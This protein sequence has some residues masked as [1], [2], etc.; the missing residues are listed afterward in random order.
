[1]GT[2]ITLRDRYG[3]ALTT[4]AVM[5]AEHY[6]EGIDLLLEQCY[7]A[8][9]RFLEAVEADPDFALAHAA[10][11]LMQMVRENGDDKVSVA[12]ALELARKTTLRE[13]RH[14]EAVSLFIH[15]QGTRALALIL[16]H[17][18]EFPR[19]ALLMRLANRLYTLGCSG[20]GVK[21]YP[22]E[23]YGM[24]RRLEPSYGD[25]W[26]FLGQDAF[27]HHEMGF[28]DASLS[29]AERSLAGRP[30]SAHAAHSVA[31]VYFEKGNVADG[32]AFLGAWLQGFDRRAPF[33]V[34]L[35][36]HQALFELAQGRYTHAVAL[37]EEA[38]R[39]SVIQKSATSLADSASLMWRMNLYSHGKPPCPVAE[40]RDQ[41]APAAESKGPAFRD[42]HAALAFAATGDGECLERLRSRLEDLAD[43]GE[44]L[45]QEMTLPLV[46]GIAAFATE[47]YDE[48]VKCLAPVMP[49]LARVGGSHAQREVFEDTLLEAYLRAGQ[50]EQAEDML[51]ERLHRRSSVR[52]SFWLARLKADAGAFAG[53][54]D[55]LQQVAQNWQH[56]DSES[57]EMDALHSLMVTTT[58]H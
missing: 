53:A 1:M 10:L 50:H 36:W 6:V 7:G 52:D 22:E 15:G 32:S 5:A 46:N 16:G 33:N 21:N 26:V 3:L 8:E 43:Q 58:D 20:A 14:V 42:A 54:R 49:Q 40:I 31:H 51:Q 57:P 27:A 9:E 13:Q 12:R 38:I 34:H 17:L 19:D 11:G 30:T 45:V 48:A 44:A 56:A 25:D 4:C 28:L 35:S 37:Y 55:L 39:P 23:L 18:A 2:P 29:L 47:A 41:A 24:M